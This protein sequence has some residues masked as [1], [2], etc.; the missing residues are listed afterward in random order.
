MIAVATADATARVGSVFVLMAMQGLIV[1]YT[2][3]HLG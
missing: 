1:L 3:A 2:C